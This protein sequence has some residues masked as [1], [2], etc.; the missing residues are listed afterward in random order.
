MISIL[1]D[2]LHKLHTHESRSIIIF[3]VSSDVQWNNRGK[4]PMPYVCVYILS[5]TNKP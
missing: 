3:L 1:C 4:A 5:N 2:C